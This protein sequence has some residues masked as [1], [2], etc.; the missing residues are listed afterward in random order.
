MY[1]WDKA[2]KLVY[3]GAGD[4]GKKCLKKYTEIKPA[5]VID[6]FVS[7]TI[8]G[9]TN[10]VRPDL[11]TNWKEYFIVITVDNK[12]V[13]KKILLDRGLKENED[14]IE[15]EIFFEIPASDSLG[16]LDYAQKQ[17]TSGNIRTGMDLIGIPFYFSQRMNPIK[18]FFADYMVTHGKDNFL[19]LHGV[20]DIDNQEMK[21]DFT[22]RM[23]PYRIP[24][25]E[26]LK[27]EIWQ[28]KR[29]MIEPK[30]VEV[31]N[32]IENRKKKENSIELIQLR[33]IYYKDLFNILKPHSVIWWGGWARDTYIIQYLAEVFGFN[34]AVAEH[35]WLKGTVNI[36]RSGIAGQSQ[37]CLD[38]GGI[39]A[40]V[41]VKE[42]NQNYWNEVKKNLLENKKIT[43][44]NKDEWNKINKMDK[45]PT[46]L[47]IGMADYGMDMN[48][49]NHYWNEKISSSV[50]GSLDAVN[51]CAKICIKNGWNLIY[52]PHP[53]EAE[54]QIIE[55]VQIS[56][57][58][59]VQ[60][61]P[62][63]LLIDFSDVSISITS[64]V[65]YEVLLRDKPLIQ[66]GKNS[67]N[68]AKCTYLVNRIEELEDKMREAVMYGYTEEQKEG[69]ERHM[70]KLLQTVLWD[71]NTVRS[72]RYGRKLEEKMLYD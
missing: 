17:I 30:E 59:F 27:E 2:R 53:K 20:Q 66:L 26:N 22:C 19:I 33:Y 49:Y 55:E 18:K 38:K 54:E 47:L 10:I 3:W 72:V 12:Q 9:N 7:K 21:R 41:G 24:T 51:E 61:I 50:T 15:Y 70:L 14:F 42:Y 48:P 40:L 5:F 39:E 67:L 29:L 4:V 32:D 65:D 35:G 64:A 68:R 60:D 16:T 31:V 13:I 56:G 43:I 36:D 57:V 44:K 28:K 1:K 45:K 52:K 25:V 69:Y 58:V 62:I 11:I 34:F 63:E 71:D 6:S 8:I 37:F 23:I 46:F